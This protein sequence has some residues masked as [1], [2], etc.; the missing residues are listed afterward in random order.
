MK[1]KG[2]VAIVTGSSSGLGRAIAILFAQEGARVVV[3]ADKNVVGGNETVSAIQEAGAQLAR[4]G[5]DERV[6]HGCSIL[7]RCRAFKR[8]SP[9]LRR[10]PPRGTRPGDRGRSRR[11]HRW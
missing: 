3:N 1:L 9:A 7:A 2:K 6:A 8:R 5:V 4:L 11:P 10:R